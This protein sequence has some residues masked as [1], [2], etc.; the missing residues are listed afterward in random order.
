MES[1]PSSCWTLDSLRPDEL[2]CILA[3]LPPED[4]VAGVA[5]TCKALRAACED[6]GLWKQKMQHTYSMLISS[7][8]FGGTLPPPSPNT[9]WRTHF[10]MFSDTFMQ[11]SHKHCGRL[12]MQIDSRIIDATDYLHAHPGE[13][14]VL[15]AAAGYDA[16]DVFASVGHSANAHR[17]LSTLVVAPRSELIP[18][19]SDAWVLCARRRS[20]ASERLSKAAAA[21]E[22]W[23]GLAR[24]VF[25]GL[26]STEGR[27]QLRS[28]LRLSMGALVRDL[29]EGRP[30]CRRFAPAVWRLTEVRLQELGRRSEDTLD[31][32]AGTQWPKTRDA[33]VQ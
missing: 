32:R 24:A 7:S 28:V 6:E 11:H 1:P 30:D 3:S 19:A 15:Q 8:C 5:P 29:T 16:T 18:A 22:S 17:F 25:S 13:P 26:R 14:E 9:S 10:F 23:P 20:G 21:H 33:C 31:T 4:I 27:A 2:L 12:V